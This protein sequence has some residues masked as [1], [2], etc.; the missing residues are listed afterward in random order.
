MGPMGDRGFDIVTG[1][2]GYTGK[3]IAERLLS[4]GRM[5]G[6]LTGHPE[7]PNPFA[8]R[9]SVAPYD[10]EDRD[11]LT[12]HLTGATTLYNT[13]WV[14]FPYGEVSFERAARNTETLVAAARNAGVRRIVHVSITNPSED[15]PYP[16]FRGKAR[17]ERTIQESG[18]GY[19]IIRPTVIFGAGDI[20][21]NNIAYLLRRLP[22]FG[23]PGS[24][25]YRV[26]PVY[27]EDVAD[28]CVQAGQRDEDEII[29]AA[30]PETFTFEEMVRL[31]AA[32]V[33]GRARIVHVP[34]A[35]A[36]A[37]AKLVGHLVGDVMLTRDELAGLM[38]NLVVTDG[39]STGHQRLSDW[40]SEN[41]G[42]VGRSYA[43]ELARHYRRST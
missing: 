25:S 30:G 22:V 32:K 9:V 15:S 12:E 17:V 5:V 18:L 8:D 36:L 23:I 10:F 40:L 4:M 34:P 20:L 42:G 38:A 16:Y 24:G 7:R 33:G 21:I 26:Q 2:F 35:L 3:H 41:S 29:D 27:V 13:Y 39:P 43:S 11:G 14:R 37:A 31:I 6:T 19:A 1:A 28:L